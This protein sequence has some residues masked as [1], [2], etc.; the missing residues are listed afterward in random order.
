MNG[1]FLQGVKPP[2][3]LSLETGQKRQHKMWTAR[4][5]VSEFIVDRNFASAA[6]HFAGPRGVFWSGSGILRRD[7]G[8]SYTGTFCCIGVL[9][10]ISRLLTVE[11]ENVLVISGERKREEVKEGEKYVRMERRIGKFMRKFVLHE[12]VNIDKISVV[13]EDVVLSVTDE[14]LPP[15]EPK[16]PKTIEVRVG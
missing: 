12:N 2:Q 5:F 9:V 3:K 13:C 16:K 15:P 1:P 8:T 11:D 7:C 6:F 14:K 4:L 10:G